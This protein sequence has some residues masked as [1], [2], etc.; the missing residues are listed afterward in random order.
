MIASPSRHH[1]A[2]AATDHLYPLLRAVS[3]MQGAVPA[4]SIELG[5]KHLELYF[6]PLAY[7]LVESLTAFPLG[8]GFQLV[9]GQG[10]ALLEGKALVRL[11]VGF[12]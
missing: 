4:V 6:E 9:T 10:N 5:P 1:W 11:T 7:E 2:G 3:V 12:G 8:R